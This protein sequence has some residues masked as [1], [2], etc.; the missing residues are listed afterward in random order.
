M[1][2]NRP[3]MYAEKC[4]LAYSQRNTRAVS[5]T[6]ITKTTASTPMSDRCAD[7]GSPIHIP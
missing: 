5:P 3:S 6:Q 4:R 2:T 7:Q 1:L